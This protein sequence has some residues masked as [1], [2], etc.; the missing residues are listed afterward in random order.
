M[1]CEEPHPDEQGVLCDKDAPCWEFHEN[2]AVGMVWD[3]EP[4]PRKQ[5]SRKRAHT[6]VATTSASART[7]PPN[8]R[9]HRHGDTYVAEFDY[10]RLNAQARRV[11]D[12]LSAGGW[13]SLA[14]ISRATD[15]PEASVSA[16]LRDLRKP[17]YGALDVDRRRRDDPS[18]GTWEYRLTR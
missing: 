5:S 13:M 7:G 16:R 4:L 8:L 18:D 12:T 3:G 1:K 2:D 6:I 14:E 10:D 9:G 17:E 15:D 11:Y